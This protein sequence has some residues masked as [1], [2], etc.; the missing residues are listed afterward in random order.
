MK[1]TKYALI[2]GLTAV[3]VSTCSAETLDG[4]WNIYEVLDYENLTTKPAR[5]QT[6]TIQISNETIS[7]SPTCKAKIYKEVYR[8]DLPFQLLLKSG[9][10]E[11]DINRFFM[12][13]FGFEPNK[14]TT[15]YHINQ[16]NI[17]NHLGNDIIFANEKLIIITG[18]PILNVFTR[19]TS[20][21]TATAPNPQSILPQNL[22]A[23]P[24][25]FK[26][27]DY[28]EHCAGNL[29]KRRG[30]PQLTISCSP[31]FFPYI[32]SKESKDSV[33]KAIGSHNYFSSG[34]RNGTDDYN[35]PVSNGL[36]PLFVV[37]PPL[38]DVIL[39]RVDDLERTESRDVTSTAYISIKNN[40]VID[41]LNDGCDF[42]EEYMCSTSGHNRKYQLTRSGQFVE[43][44]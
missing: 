14:M 30:I 10:R 40:K 18:G 29:P 8:A 28:M 7:I 34:G 21:S 25:P 33:S 31:S 4:M 26:S 44:K 22:K 19:S 11:E 23:T 27:A 38:G 24:L 43:L 42:S 41:Q 37:F 20:R 5:T 35:N 17:C 36:H 3:C 12:K 13:H 2:S 9:E 39:A 32:A 1:A 16:S 15:Y 6:S